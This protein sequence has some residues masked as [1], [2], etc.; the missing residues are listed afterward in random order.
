MNNSSL[1]YWLSLMVLF[2]ASYGGW[3]LW[4]VKQFQQQ[5]ATGGITLSE[6][7]PLT[8]FELTER[9]GKPFRS[10][11]MRG[12]VWVASFFFANCQGTCSRLNGNIKRLN[13]EENLDG[14]TWVSM[15]VDPTNDTLPVLNEYAERFS[16][17]PQRWL[18]CRADF[19]YIKRVGQDFLKLPVLW[20]DHSDTV[21]VVDKAGKV[22]GY[23]DALSNKE[24]VEL[25][26]LLEECL[27][28]DPPP[29]A[30]AA[31]P[32]ADAVPA[33]PLSGADSKEAA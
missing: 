26:K 5:Q 7:P 20:K 4:Q 30:E 22:R 14:V 28:E 12:K 9:S 17:D 33:Q 13:R 23:F 24:L 29:V 2:A 21:A 3:K 1:P 8:E 18:F 31:Q 6:G 16:A 15:T 19:R 25:T 10:R 27:A 11:D 32:P